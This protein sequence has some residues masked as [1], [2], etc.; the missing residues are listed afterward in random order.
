MYISIT[1]LSF[2]IVTFLYI[3]AITILIIPIF[4]IYIRINSKIF[5]S[6]KSFISFINWQ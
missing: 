6:P 3:P 4:I 1:Q 2:Y 5:S